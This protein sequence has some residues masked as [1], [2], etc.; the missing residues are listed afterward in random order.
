MANVAIVHSDP[1]KN[2]VPITDIN[3]LPVKIGT[4]GINPSTYS[5]NDWKEEGTVTYTLNLN[6]EGKWLFIK[7]DESAKSARYAN[8]SNNPTMTTYTLASADYSTLTYDLLEVL[9]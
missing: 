4:G 8:E 7:Y 6:S 1:S 9:N 2:E 5:I 3:P